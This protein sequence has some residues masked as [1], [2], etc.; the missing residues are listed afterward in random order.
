MKYR[1]YLEKIA[2]AELSF[3]QCDENNCKCHAAVI[4]TDLKT[5][6]TGITKQ[7]LDNVKSK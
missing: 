7:M 2:E 6:E 5:F 4:A 1:S 3:K